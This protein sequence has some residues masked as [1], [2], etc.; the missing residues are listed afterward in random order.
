MVQIAVLGFGTVGSGVVELIDRNHDA[1]EGKFTEGVHVKHILDLRDFPDSPYNDRVTHDFDE[2][3]EDPEIKIICE[4]MG[5]KEPAYTFSKKA[6]SKGISVCTSNKE[7]VAAY[8]PELIRIARENNCNYMFEASVGGGIPIIRPMNT[9][10]TPEYITSIVGILNGTTNYIMTRMEKAGLTFEAALK[11][12]QDNGYAERN[13]AAD[14]EGHDACRK[15]AILSSLMSGKTV[16][17]EDIP[18]EGITGITKPDHAYARKLNMAIKLLGVSNRS[19]D[20]KDLSVRTAPFLVPAG[21]PLHGVEDVFNGVYVH[22]NMVD[23]LMFYGRGAGKFPTASAVVADVID[24]AKHL[25]KH[26]VC[27]W[28]HEVLALADTSKESYAYF[29]RVEAKDQALVQELFGDVNYV[30]ADQ[31]AGDEVAFV[32]DMM[33]EAQFQEKADKL[34][35]MITRI[36]VLPKA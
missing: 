28:D 23:D 21:H 33:T 17:Y 13:P 12:A 32:T 2:I 16:R 25:G 1:I 24:C 31:E 22:G 11:E 8:G 27:F 5:G 18:C 3:L 9:A 19:E 20:G 6:L 30:E 29:V 15:I 7:L 4:T 35:G 36:R 34:T 14:I 10:L 26:V